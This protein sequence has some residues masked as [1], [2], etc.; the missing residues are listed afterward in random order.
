MEG[1]EG[2]LS[3]S[4]DSNSDSEEDE[5]EVPTYNFQNNSKG[6]A[7]EINIDDIWSVL[8]DIVTQIHKIFFDIAYQLDSLFDNTNW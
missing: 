8:N 4:S 3:S 1:N 2:D 6:K 7:P 5:E